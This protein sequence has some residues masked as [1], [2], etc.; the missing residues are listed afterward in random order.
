[1]GLAVT[2][3]IGM[4]LQAYHSSDLCPSVALLLIFLETRYGLGRHVATLSP[5]DL[6]MFL[7]V[8][9]LGSYYT[10]SLS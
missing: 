8:C 9:H 3:L 7:K 2:T 4:Y 1:M 10:S 6:A 5:E